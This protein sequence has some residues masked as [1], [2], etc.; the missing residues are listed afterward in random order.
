MSEQASSDLAERVNREIDYC[1]L[2][3]EMTLAE[4]VGVLTVVASELILDE[5]STGDSDGR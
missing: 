4:A 3:Y 2:E 5:R 1:R